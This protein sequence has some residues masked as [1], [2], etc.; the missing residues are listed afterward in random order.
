MI[1]AGHI[2]SQQSG[3]R[4]RLISIGQPGLHSE[5]Q[6]SQGI[7]VRFCFKKENTVLITSDV[8][9]PIGSYV[10]NTWL[11]HTHTLIVALFWEAVWPLVVGV[12]LDKMLIIKGQLIDL[13]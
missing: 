9:V 2:E 10:C 1:F 5:F 8:N 13:F 12:Y 4:G 6:A 7:I 3:V 11:P